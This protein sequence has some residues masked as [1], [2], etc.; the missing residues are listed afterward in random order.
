MKLQIGF[1]AISAILFFTGMQGNASAQTNPPIRDPRFMHT[2]PKQPA[3]NVDQSLFVPQTDTDDGTYVTFGPPSSVPGATFDRN[4][5][6]VLFPG[7]PL[8]INSAGVITGNYYDAV[9]NSHGFIR[10]RDGRMESFDSPNAG[11][12]PNAGT[13]P[14][15]STTLEQLPAA[16][17]MPH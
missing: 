10:Y 15:P 9:E 6:A 17:T 12:G 4:L 8:P 3:A 7:A 14:A 2:T 1:T 13:F 11:T 5:Y 16:L